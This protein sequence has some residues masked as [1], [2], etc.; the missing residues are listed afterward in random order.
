MDRLFAAC[1]DFYHMKDYGD[2]RMA[3]IAAVIR[4]EVAD[5]GSLGDVSVYEGYALGLVA[6]D[7]GCTDLAGCDLSTVAL[8]RARSS[9]PGTFVPFDLNR[10]Y[11]DPAMTLPIPRPDV[12]LVCECLYY[13]GPV[14]NLAWSRPWINRSQKLAFIGALQRHARKAVLFQ[15]FGARQKQAIGD[16]V[17]EAGGRK[18]EDRWGIWLLP[19]AS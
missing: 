15:H 9:L 18:A 7:L 6:Q 14:A 3:A 12:L 4:S 19:A 17:T 11:D 2:E 16:L 13:V 10:L 8:E 1:P 5:C